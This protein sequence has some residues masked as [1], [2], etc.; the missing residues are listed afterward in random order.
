MICVTPGEPHRSFQDENRSL[1]IRRSVYGQTLAPSCV[2]IL[3]DF[4]EMDCLPITG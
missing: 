1:E 4:K 2:V 3:C